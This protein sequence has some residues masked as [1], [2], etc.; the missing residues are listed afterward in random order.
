MPSARTRAPRLSARARLLA[1]TLLLAT[2]A[3]LL[4]AAVAGAAASIEGVWSFESG[5]IAI[6][7]QPDGTFAGTVV[8]ET[9]F[10]ECEHAVG[11][12]IWTDIVAQ[13]DGSYWGHHQWLFE[14]TCAPNPELG[15]TAWRVEEQPDGSKYL[16][17][18]FSMPGSSQPQ[19]A[20]NGAESGV[21]YGCDNSMLTAP[22]PV[23]PGAGALGEKERLSLPAARRCLSGRRFEIHL[24]PPTYDPFKSVSVTIGGHTIATSR[25][26]RHFVA[27]IDLRGRR[28]GA[29]TVVVHATTV[30][31]HR[32]SGRRT[33]HTCASRPKRHKP[34][35]LH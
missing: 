12:R 16:R 11:E 27:T 3:A 26:G 5:Q 15:P 2:I 31:G 7:A 21:T 35:P 30:L 29:F 13:P 32:L 1:L 14:S 22:L 34:A 6:T 18:C 24:A 33:Y 8:V 4:G 23:A 17:V 28:R 19:I 10:A 9:K 25:R 20:P